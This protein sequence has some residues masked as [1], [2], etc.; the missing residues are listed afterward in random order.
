MK[1]GFSYYGNRYIKH[2]EEDL[3]EI[4]KIS[5][6]IVHAVSEED[7]FYHKKALERLFYAT[8]KAGLELWV[9]LWGFGG[10]FGGECFSGFLQK[11]PS[12]TQISSNNEQ[13]PAVCMRN[14]KFIEF[15]NA[16]IDFF[17]SIG[18]DCIFID[19]PHLYF[20]LHMFE[21]KIFSC[22]CGSCMYEFKKIHG[23]EMPERTT[24][25]VYEFMIYTIKNFVEKICRI[26]KKKKLKTACTIYAV[27]GIKKYEKFWD[28][29]SSIETLDIFGADPYWRS[30]ANILKKS[31]KKF[32]SFWSDR[33]VTT[34]NKKNKSSIVWLQCFRIP[35]KNLE[36]LKIAYNE[37]K[38]FK[39]DYA[40]LWS[41]DAGE[42]LDTTLSENSHG[43][44]E[45]I[46]S[47][48]D[49]HQSR[50]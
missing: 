16:A 33:I 9:D 42:I 10:V 26:A 25:E 48:F 18:A 36:E 4:K 3:E 44:R 6:F 5:D 43:L 12:A 8:K 28:E 50:K 24:D 38:S 13:L 39:P 41:Y 34:A 27:S 17:S 35:S 23:Y 22:A 37:I 15:I 30:P 14:E 32:V 47:L 49:I 29:I 1:I 7:F 46:K 40:G 45:A 31:V 2:F 21:E 20:K 11:N 19:E